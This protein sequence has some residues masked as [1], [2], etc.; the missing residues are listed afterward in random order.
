MLASRSRRGSFRLR[1]TDAMCT[2]ARN[3]KSKQFAPKTRLHSQQRTLSGGVHWSCRTNCGMQVDD[4]FSRST[5]ATP[6]WPGTTYATLA[7]SKRLTCV[8]QLVNRH[9]SHNTRGIITVGMEHGYIVILGAT[10]IK[11]VKSGW[12]DAL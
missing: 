2:I 11:V 4:P 5:I 9:T 8:N 3:W 1:P 7:A 12:L 10:A 6:R